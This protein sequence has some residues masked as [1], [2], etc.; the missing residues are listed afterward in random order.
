MSE[1]DPTGADAHVTGDAGGDE[2]TA[3]QDAD[4]ITADYGTGTETLVDTN[5]D[6]YADEVILHQDGGPDEYFTHSFGDG[7]ELDTVALDYNHDGQP[8]AVAADTDHDGHIDTIDVDR[9]H[10]GI[11]DEVIHLDPAGHVEEVD[12]DN[13]FDGQQDMEI[14]S[15]GHDGVLDTVHYDHPAASTATAGQSGH[16]SLSPYAAN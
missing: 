7:H 6:G 2:Y 10:D 1:Y 11:V 5:H 15:S 13:N 16:E 8:D 3:P 14:T 4:A 9:N 12:L